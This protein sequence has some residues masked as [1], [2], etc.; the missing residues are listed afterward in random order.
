MKE[1]E[2]LYDK[3]E[4]MFGKNPG[5]LN[6]LEQQIDVGLQMEY[7][8]FS[9]RMASEY[10]AEW[11]EQQKEFLF[12]ED[13]PIGMK[14]MLLARLASIDRVACFRAIESYAYNPDE[15][16]RDWAILSLNESRMHLE[17]EFMDENQIFIST[18]LGGKKD[19][20]RY[21][22]VLISRNKQ[23]LDKTQQKIIENEFAY[24]LKKYGT[25]LEKVD[26]SEYLASLM[27]LMPIQYP[28]KQVIE[29]TISE[30]N[31]YGNFLRDN[32]I[33]TNV[34]TLSFN[35]IKEFIEKKE[36]SGS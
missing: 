30:C 4:E 26:F 8:E 17:G 7:F 10:D 19:K 15:E 12:D 13:Y 21:F 27:L 16:L 5:N 20:L 18:G 1:S 33:V 3:I 6:I 14:R 34:K 24:L 28:I 2:N 35:E 29:E 36:G 31:L 9:R 25:Q 32:F 23:N 11:A 22:L